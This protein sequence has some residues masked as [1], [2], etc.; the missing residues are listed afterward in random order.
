MPLAI[1]T[2]IRIKFCKDIRAIFEER[3]KTPCQCSDTR[4]IKTAMFLRIAAAGN[5]DIWM[6][7][8]DLMDQ[9]A[10]ITRAK[11]PTK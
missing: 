2:P 11:T 5:E 1:M 6:L 3:F 8:D 10:T 9:Q 4:I 7:L